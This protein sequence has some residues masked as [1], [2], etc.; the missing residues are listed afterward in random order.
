MSTYYGS[1]YADTIYGGAYGDY[2][3]GY[4][5]ADTLYGQGGDDFLSGGA[6]DDYLYGGD[7]A[8]DLQGGSGYND[9]W[10]GYGADWL[11]VSARDGGFSDDLVWDFTFD[12]DR[13]DLTAWGVSDFSQLE[14]LLYNDATG[15]AAFNAYYNGYDHVVTLDGISEGALLAADF[16]FADPAAR[17]ATGTAYD[18]VMFGSRYADTL[19][20]GG[21]GDELLGGLGNDRLNGGTGADTLYGGAGND[22]YQVDNAGD[23]TL[24]LSGKGVDT[25]ESNI[26]WMLAAQVENL[27]LTGSAAI[28]GTGNDLGNTISGNGAAN[29]LKGFGSADTINAGGGNDT[30]YGGT[31]RDTMFGG[32]GAD[33]FVFTSIKDSVASSADRINDFD[34]FADVIDLRQIDANT[35]LSGDQAFHWSSSFTSHAGEA[36]LAYD[37]A[38]NR[39]MLSLDQNGDGLADF[40][41]Q[42][43]GHPLGDSGFL[44]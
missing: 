3:Y 26:G 10:G 29:V 43:N 25:V 24:E 22:T 31:G 6:G 42:I 40:K 1:N 17:D 34:P 39:T 38:N 16:V 27:T 4:A 41:L 36:V 23:L 14:W 20:G 15:S 37:A 28:N 32:A 9:Y 12:E 7:G 2:L 11:I 21:G 18:D 33:S 44:L 5:G 8:D 30:I 35:A 19:R 13:V